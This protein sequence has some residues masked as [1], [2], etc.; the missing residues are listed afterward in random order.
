[1]GNTWRCYLSKT[2]KIISFFEKWNSFDIFGL[3]N[4]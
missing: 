3:M 2:A 4:Y 1:M